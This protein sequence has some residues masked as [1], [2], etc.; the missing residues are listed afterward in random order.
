MVDFHQQQ[1]AWMD[2]MPEAPTFFPTREQFQD[3]LAYIRS[4]Q[5]EAA[6][7]GAGLERMHA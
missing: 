3:P 2:R 4:I 5:Q 6:Q 1:A 7:Y